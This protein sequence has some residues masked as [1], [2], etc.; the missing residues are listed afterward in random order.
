MEYRMRAIDLMG[1]VEPWPEN[2]VEWVRIVSYAGR[3]QGTVTDARG[4]GLGGVTVQATD[5]I[6]GQMITGDEG[7][8]AFH[9]AADV[10]YT[11]TASLVGDTATRNSASG[12]RSG[13]LTTMT[14]VLKDPINALA[15]GGFEA[16][17]AGWTPS[18]D[19]HVAASGAQSIEGSHAFILG[20]G[21]YSGFSDAAPVADRGDLDGVAATTHSTITQTVTVPD[22]MVQPTL[23]FS[24]RLMSSYFGRP[25]AVRIFDAGGSTLLAEANY[26]DASVWTHASLDLT[27]QAGQSVDVVFDVEAD[28]ASQ[29]QIP[30]SIFAL[31]D[32]VVGPGVRPQISG[33]MP[34]SVP[35]SSGTVIV[36]GSGFSPQTILT[37][38]G[39][40][41][42]VT[43]LDANTLSAVVPA[44]LTWGRQGVWASDPAGFGDLAPVSLV[45]GH[46]LTL[47]VLLRS[48]PGDTWALVP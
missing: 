23:S 43:W 34:A 16:G 47:P 48:A 5:S 27:S 7:L 26:A 30:V 31:D 46:S 17:V 6:E 20:D 24:Y 1:N 19:Y 38:G 41:A 13:D 9:F 15:N 33:L 36:N 11:V 8:F 35:N 39:Q 32:I 22:A 42:Q 40:P 44:G 2:P 25:L 4:R 3:L 21:F 45:V 12:W 18:G 29:F 14:I 37:I 10:P 28:A